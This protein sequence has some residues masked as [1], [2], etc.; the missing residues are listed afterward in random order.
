[1]RAD[2]VEDNIS[3]S[4]IRGTESLDDVVQIFLKFGLAG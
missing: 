1:V 3:T 2:G 4:L